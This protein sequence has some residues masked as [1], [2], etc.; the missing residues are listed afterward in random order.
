M[1][2]FEKP[3]LKILRNNFNILK[4]SRFEL[5]E[6]IDEE[7]NFYKYQFI[8]SK[9]NED[10]DEIYEII[11]EN[12]EGENS[13]STQII[14]KNKKIK[15]SFV[16][17]FS[18]MKVIEGNQLLLEVSTKGYPKPKINWYHSENRILPS[19]N[20]I[21][22]QENFDGVLAI[23]SINKS[24]HEGVYRCEAKNIYGECVHSENIIVCKRTPKFIERLR[25]TEV[26]ENDKTLLTV[27][28]STT[29]DDVIWLKDGEMITQQNQN[30]EF[31]TDGY[32]RKLLI[33]KANVSH[34]G[35]YKC[36]LGNEKCSADLVV[37][38]MSPEITKTMKD[39]NII[40][41]ES[42][43]FIVELSKGDAILE[44]FKD[45]K[46]IIF[47]ERINLEIDG[48]QQRL[49]IQEAKLEDAAEYSCSLN[50][51]TSKAKLIVQYPSTEFLV[52]LQDEYSVDEDCEIMFT[53]EISR[54]DVDVY[55]YKNGEEMR[56]SSNVKFISKN[57]TRKLII[58]H[59]KTSDCGEYICLAKGDQTKTMLHVSKEQRVFNLKLK[60]FNVKEN[61]TATLSTEV[62][63]E[64]FKLYWYKDDEP[65]ETDERFMTTESGKHRKLIIRNVI[66][67]DR[68]IYTAV[69]EGQRTS[70]K[71]SVLS[72]P[73]VLSDNRRYTAVR[74]KSFTI[75]VP[76]DGYPIPKAE[77]Y[78]AGRS[79]KTSKKVSIEILMSRTIMTIKNFDDSDV[80]SYKLYL[81]NAIGQFTTHFEV[82]II[83]KPDPPEEPICL[84]ITN[85]SLI[86]KWNEVTKNN[87][88]PITNYIVEFKESKSNVWK[89]YNEFIKEENVKIKNLKHNFTYSFRV[90]SVNKAGRSNPSLESKAVKIEEQ[91]LEEPPVIIHGLKPSVSTYPFGTVKFECKI[92][93]NPTP[94][95][96]WRK[97]GTR[98]NEDDNVIIK[99]QKDICSLVIKECRFDW[100]DNY[101]CIASNEYGQAKTSCEL[102]IEE[103][104]YAQFDQR[105]TV[106]KVKQGCSHSIYCEIFGYPYP[107]VYWHKDGKPAEQNM[108][109]SIDNSSNKTVLT[110]E[111]VSIE[112]SGIYTLQLVNSA[113]ETKYD[114][115][116]K[117]LN[118]PGP[119]DEP[120]RCSNSDDYSIELS[121]NPPK[122]DGGSPILFYLIE[123]SEIKNHEWIEVDQVTANNFSHRMYEF[124][125]GVKYR[126]RI[127]SINEF[128]TS[129]PAFSETI[130]CK[131][132]YDRPSPPN[133]PI[134]TSDHTKESF[135]LYWNPPDSDGNCPILEYLIEIKEEN[136]RVWQKIGSV[137]GETLS[138]KIEDL[139][140]EKAYNLKIICRNKIGYSD[141]YCP[142]KLITVKCK[143]GAPT[144]PEGPLKISEMTNTSLTLSWKPPMSDG[145]LALTGYIIERKLYFENN[146]IRETIL[147]PDELSYTTSN[148]SAKYEY[149]FRVFAENA[150][151][152][153][154]PL[155]SQAIQ[156]SQNASPPGIPSAPLEMRAVSPSAI[157]IEWGKPEHD[158]GSPI[159]GYVIAARDAR[160]T[161]WMEVGKVD[162]DVHRLQIKDLQEG[163]FYQVR[164]L[165]QNE[166]GLSD[167]LEA[168]EPIKVIRPPGMYNF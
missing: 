84:N 132:P 101:E 32:Y 27:K 154:Q 29:E 18:T 162:A 54:S 121:W 156:L 82:L 7:V 99:Q 79:L 96:E 23:S 119:P 158:G 15:P 40:Y 142:D 147:N 8:C 25:D 104:P 31:I 145:G 160:R 38:E 135:I 74:N 108:E 14:F 136:S 58:R 51:Q 155:E 56:E 143:F 167:P 47:N 52:R 113:S 62:L 151:G 114:F 122:D 66:R 20:T 73:K 12:S 129:E 140:N 44:W 89:E 43:Q 125:S 163:H 4:F 48:K 157:V 30:Y 42:A 126:F 120:I 90:Y 97:G 35:E 86:L 70:A 2:S 138:M 164:V 46:Q 11:A 26:Y 59:A 134:R 17:V 33:E 168:E 72:P 67:Q 83:D 131:S 115:E 139:I 57:T 152:K 102:L 71:M 63:N 65:L 9:T 153:S 130:I 13:I 53:V 88:S 81:E 91:D 78:Y 111:S 5:I 146:W 3:K 110:I 116:V 144:S 150:L 92:I 50:N 19:S 103:K 21:I 24:N 61:E 148:L 117:M 98:I 16:K 55:W 49:I 133:G 37:I 93:G 6:E 128:G 118:R 159:I 124:K 80:G 10:D 161:M 137:D 76:F 60:D 94:E 68:G 105:L 87:G 149:N 39:V 165:A 106:V 41:G 69:C 123:A 22:R 112:N 36:I 85:N 95:I 100:A 64:S 28:L 1:H 109:I 166:I 77:W 45:G 34:Q 127:S 141:P 75:D 107:E